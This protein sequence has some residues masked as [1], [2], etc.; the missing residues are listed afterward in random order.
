[1]SISASTK[2]YAVLGHPVRHSLS[3][4]MHNAA[5]RALGMDAVYLAL[6]MPPGRSASVLPWL[7]EAGFGGLNV[8]VPLKEEWFQAVERLE[9]SARLMG[10]VNTVLFRDGHSVGCNTDGAGF[11]RAVQEMPDFQFVGQRVLLLGAGGAARAAAMAA[12]AEQCAEVTV[13]NRTPERAEA[14]A[15]DVHR[16]FP[17][18]RVQGLSLKGAEEAAREADLIVQC[19]SAG[20]RADEPP[21][22][23]ARA[24]HAGQRVFDMI[25]SQHR[26]PILCEAEAAGAAV[27]NGLGML[28]WQGA[29]AFEWWTGEKAPVDVMR[30]ALT[31]AMTNR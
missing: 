2:P 26:T 16:A 9:E 22:L 5:F 31:E 8:T 12:A 18:V 4:C 14:L 11:V 6:D 17:Q 20:L 1:M 27:A 28:L 3:P 13:A 7:E 21:L 23:R 15:G 10:A 29:L 24:F 19:T 30:R 25:Y